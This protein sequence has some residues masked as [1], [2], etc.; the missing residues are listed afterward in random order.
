M[1]TKLV[2]VTA[3]IIPFLSEHI[4]QNLVA[5]QLPG[6]PQSV[7]HYDYPTADESRI[8]ADLSARMA[9]L[10]RVV[11][12]ARSVR[13]SAKLKVRQPLAEL[14]VVPAD[15]VEREAVEN[16]TEHVLEELNVKAVSVRAEADELI[17]VTV[18]PNMK[19]LGPKYGRNA[20]GVREA[21]AELDGR[22]VEAALARGEAVSIQLAGS[23]VQLE[24]EDLSVTTLIW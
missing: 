12:L 8:D 7:H 20:A 5:R 19:V 23:T 15:N 9:A 2:E 21:I 3:P 13:T 22:V 17:A 18:N 1:L 10:L 4:Y 16:F 6:A 24:P 11:S 14:I